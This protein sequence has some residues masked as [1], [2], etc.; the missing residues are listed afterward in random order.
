MSKVRRSFSASEK[1]SII[2]EADQFGVTQTLRKHSLSPSV[3]R[4]WKESFI[5]VGVS[6]IHSYSMQRNPQMDAME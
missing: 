4:R 1:L 6:N 3:F 5:E 2:N